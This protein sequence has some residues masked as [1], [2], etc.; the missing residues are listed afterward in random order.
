VTSEA[1]A[2]AIEILSCLSD[3]ELEQ[4]RSAVR[5]LMKRAVER[6]AA[7]I[8]ATAVRAIQLSPVEAAWLWIL[9]QTSPEFLEEQFIQGD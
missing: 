2:E 7:G 9:W 3:T 1:V 5:R 4:A 6:R 8:R